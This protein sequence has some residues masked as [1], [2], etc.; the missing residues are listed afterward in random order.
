MAGQIA[1]TL[2]PSVVLPILSQM[3][4]SLVILYVI[5]TDYTAGIIRKRNMRAFIIIS[6]I[7]LDIVHCWQW[8]WHP[9]S[10][11]LCLYFCFFIVV[12]VF[13]IPLCNNYSILI[14][15]QTQLWRCPYN[16]LLL[17]GRH[18]SVLHWTII[19][20]LR[21]KVCTYGMCKKIVT[22]WDPIRFYKV[23]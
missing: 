7:I 14:N 21:A 8:M 17:V 19:R 15:L 13:S 20:S 10:L 22:Q 18:V 9:R 23:V 3:T 6:S 2:R 1:A 4:V 5:A 16:L 12:L 11:L